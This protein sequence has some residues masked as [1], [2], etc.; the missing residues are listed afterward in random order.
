LRFRTIALS[1]IPGAAHVDLGRTGRGLLFFSLFAFCVNGSL[2]SPFVFEGRGVRTACA[3]AAVG[4]WIVALYD[5][6]RLAARSAGT[7]A[8]AAPENAEKKVEK[9]VA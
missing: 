3:L 9:P 7:P 5:A 4:I 6:V 8:P 1:M 2:I